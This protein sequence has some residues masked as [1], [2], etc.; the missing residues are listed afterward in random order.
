MKHKLTTLLLAAVFFVAATSAQTISLKQLG[1]EGMFM[2]TSFGCCSVPFGGSFYTLDDYSVIYKTDLTTG[3]QSRL[4]TETYK[5]YRFFFENNGRIYVINNDGSMS[6]TDPATGA[7]VSISGVDTWT[8]IERVFT[9]RHLCYGIENGGLYIFPT[10]NKKLNRKIG[11]D[12]FYNVGTLIKG[13]TLLLSLIGDGS[14]YDINLNTG[15]WRRVGKGKDWKRQKTGAVLNGKLYSVDADE[16]FYETDLAD[17]T[18]RQL[19]NTQFGKAV[20]LFPDSG[21]LYM[22]DRKGDLFLVNLN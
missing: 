20:Y 15:V 3:E 21:K 1:K 5:N 9:V 22:I 2:H 17:G 10:V 8:T 19:D 7:W 6:S 4:G 18:R 14:L 13:D 16:A 12:D 11:K